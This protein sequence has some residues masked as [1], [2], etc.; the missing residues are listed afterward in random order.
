MFP[1]TDIMAKNLITAR[2]ETPLA[3][4]IRLLV[5]NRITGIP[6]ID[7]GSN[8]VGILSEYDVLHL[9]LETDG[10]G[11]KTAGDVMTKN[12]IAFEDTVTAIEVCEFFMNNPSKRRVPIV[13][14]GK[15]VGLVS[16]ADIVKL[17]KKL[18]HM[19]N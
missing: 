9:L 19:D 1:I 14:A 12:V 10:S 4:I 7:E 11:S 8:L 15:L 6:V 13:H 2:K 17:I 18:R 5:D 3:E 16:R